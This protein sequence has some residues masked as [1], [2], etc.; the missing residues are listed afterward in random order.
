VLWK[1]QSTAIPNDKPGTN[2]PNYLMEILTQRS[3]LTS[4]L[5]QFI[6]HGE[7]VVIVFDTE[8]KTATVEPL[9]KKAKR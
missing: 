9:P 3:E 6:A 5:E 1:T 4:F 7:N 8:A 2:D